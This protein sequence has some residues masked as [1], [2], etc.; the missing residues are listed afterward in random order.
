[1]TDELQALAKEILETIAAEDEAYFQ[2]KGF[3]TTRTRAGDCKVLT[4]FIPKEQRSLDEFITWRDKRW[5]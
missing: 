5:I 2:R 3:Y 1:M 4:F